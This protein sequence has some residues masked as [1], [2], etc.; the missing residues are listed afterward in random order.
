MDPIQAWK[1]FLEGIDTSY[2]E[3]A[4][5]LYKAGFTKPAELPH[6][7][8]KDV[9]TVPKGALRRIKAAFAGGRPVQPHI[10][11]VAS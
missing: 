6:A 7:D 5:E 2:A 11:S 10:R 3:Y 8:E 1:V 4:S 9:P